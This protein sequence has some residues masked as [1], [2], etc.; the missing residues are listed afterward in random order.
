MLSLYVSL[1]LFLID[2]SISLFF[3]LLTIQIKIEKPMSKNIIIRMS[4][5]GSKVRLVKLVEHSTSHRRGTVAMV[6]PNG[7]AGYAAQLL[8]CLAH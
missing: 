6:V 5:T 8:G 3:F 2:N 4:K 7:G 1:F